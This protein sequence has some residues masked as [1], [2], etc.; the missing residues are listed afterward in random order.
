VWI[1]WLAANCLGRDFGLRRPVGEGDLDC[2]LGGLQEDLPE[3]WRTWLKTHELGHYLLHR[4]DQV[5]DQIFVAKQQTQVDAFAGFVLVGDPRVDAVDRPWEIAARAGVP[6]ECVVRWLGLT[7][8]GRPFFL[9]RPV[10]RKEVGPNV[11]KTVV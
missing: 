7:T 2:A 3:S 1:A 8:T 10:N 9:G 11:S 6:T 5:S 4:S